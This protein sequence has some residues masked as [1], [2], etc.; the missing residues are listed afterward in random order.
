MEEFVCRKGG[1]K[2]FGKV[3]NQGPETLPP[4]II[5]H[6]FTANMESV[7]KYARFFAR[8]GYRAFIFDFCGGGFETTSDGT[9]QDYMTPLTEV[10]DLKVIVDYVL[11]RE[12]VD[13][14]KLTL[15]GC[16]QGGFVA[17]IVAA[18]MKDRVADLILFYPALC[19][20]DDA[21]KGSM[22]IMKF[23]PNNIPHHIGEGRMQVS[24]SYPR[25]VIHMDIY[26][27]IKRY[28][29]RV[30]LVHGSK[31]DV[32]PISYSEKAYAVYQ[33]NGADVTYEIIEGAGHGFS[34]GYMEEAYSVLKNHIGNKEAICD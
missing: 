26:D 24:G 25:S 6:G 22:Q 18:E 7:E 14:E 2:I 10:D 9:L 32:V 30:L 34:E 29:K 27:E 4:I 31:D 3:Y 5:C 16:S 20:P 17:S 23:D 15:M 12:D 21:R 11:N 19:I 8:K 28:N 1:M 13:K 33:E